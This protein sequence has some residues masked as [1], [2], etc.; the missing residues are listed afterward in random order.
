MR[1][2]KSIQTPLT[3]KNNL[4]RVSSTKIQS[5]DQP[6]IQRSR[7]SNRSSNGFGRRSGG[8]IREVVSALIVSPIGRPERKTEVHFC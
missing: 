3:N 4:P 2:D 5:D 7:L 6:V 1:L 8:V